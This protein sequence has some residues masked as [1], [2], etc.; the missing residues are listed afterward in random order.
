MNVKEIIKLFTGF[1]AIVIIAGAIFLFN[2]GKGDEFDRAKDESGLV[3]SD[4]AIYVSEQM[5][6]DSVSVQIARLKSSGFVVI[7]EDS[8]GKPG[9]IL[10]TSNLIKAGEKENL[11][12][13][14]LSRPTKG[15]ETIYAIL[16]L[17]D[18]DGRFDTVNDK[19]I[20][21]PIG[22]V[23]MMMVVTISKDADEAGVVNPQNLK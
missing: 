15:E 4:N 5:S 19:R 16:Y 17:D 8:E 6:G 10:G 13:I 21:D 18:G 20:I 7:F 23:P 3:V 12:P 14:I 2:S 11:P 22:K 1:G 9:K